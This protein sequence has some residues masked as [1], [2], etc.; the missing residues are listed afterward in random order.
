MIILDTRRVINKMS[1]IADT[2]IPDEEIP[3]E[4]VIVSREHF[5]GTYVGCSRVKTLNLLRANKNKLLYVE[6]A[7]TLL[8]NSH[9]DFGHEALYTIKKFITEHHIEIVF[10]IQDNVFSFEDFLIHE[11]INL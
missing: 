2:V 5:I 1:S 3:K 7:Q 9:D 6:D 8:C 11:N 4:K 10:E